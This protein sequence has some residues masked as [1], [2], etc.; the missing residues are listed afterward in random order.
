MSSKIRVVS[1]ED[2]ELSRI[3]LNAALEQTGEIEIVGDAATGRQGIQ[4]LGST[5][6]DVAVVDIGLPDI[7][8][9]EVVQRFKQQHDRAE[10]RVLMLTMHDD[11]DSILAAFAA[12]A[13]SY[14]LKDTDIDTLVQAVQL[15]SEGNAWIDPSIAR[16]VLKHSQTP[17]ET[18]DSEETSVAIRSIDPEE[19]QIIES[20]PLTDRELDVLQLIV[21]GYNNATI[22]ERLHITVGT[23]KTHVRSILSKMCADDR[24]QAAVRALRSGLVN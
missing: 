1:I 16:V 17:S 8:G 22:A 18:G 19:L 6:P 5:L 14:C 9:I 24:T 10:T 2:N 4:V 11:D 7:D 20:S 15:T 3:G 13:D 21:A 12:G 23:V